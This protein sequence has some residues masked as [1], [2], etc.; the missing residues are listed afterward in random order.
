MTK[1]E[2]ARAARKKAAAFERTELFAGK[3][4]TKSRTHSCD[5]GRSDSKRKPEGEARK[6]WK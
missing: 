1:S 3:E 4:D 6:K 5:R 2:Y